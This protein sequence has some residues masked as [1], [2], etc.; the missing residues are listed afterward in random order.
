MGFLS[1]LKHL[2][3][4]GNYDYF[5]KAIQFILPPR[6]LLLGI[7]LLINVFSV[8]LNPIGWIYL[9]LIVL[10]I[11]ILTFF[12]TIPLKFY[13]L[14]TLKAIATLPKAFFLMFVSVFKL[15]GANKKFIHTKHGT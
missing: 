9:W 15:K 1:S 10:A 8:F 5:D 13:N 14:N 11:T 12:I 7:L 6:V 3:L 4:H 2:F